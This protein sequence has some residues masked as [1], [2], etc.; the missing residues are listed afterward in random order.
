VPP[1]RQQDGGPVLLGHRLGECRHL[2]DIGDVAI[3][4]AVGAATLHP[5][6]VLDDEV[7]EDGGVEDGLE[8]PVGGASRSGRLG[9]DVGVP[10][11]NVDR[12]DLRQFSRPEGG[13]QPVFDEEF[14]LLPGA[15]PDVGTL[16]QPEIGVTG[17]RDPAELGV[18]PVATTDGRRGG[19]EKG[20]GIGSLVE[21]V[22]GDVAQPVVPVAG[23]EEATRELPHAAE[24]A[25]VPGHCS[26]PSV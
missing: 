14:V 22:R 4:D 7:V 25:S 15:R 9:S 2:I 11:A 3:T 17:E 21:R 16:G 8:Q 13:L 23:L 18:D 1:R 6:R 24:M 20:I 10:G 19:I 5:A 12:R 26:V